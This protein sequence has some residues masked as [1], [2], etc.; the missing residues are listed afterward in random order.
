MKK[1]FLALAAL[2]AMTAVSCVKDEST[3][4]HITDVKGVVINEVYTFSD[5]SEADDLD[6]IELYNTTNEDID[7]TDVLMWEG[8]G[9]EEAWAFPKGTVIKAK[10]YYVV[11]CDK[12]GLL[13]DPVKYPAWGL[14]KG[15]D[16]FVVLANSDLKVIDEVKLPSLNENESYGRVTDGSADWQIFQQGTKGVKN[17][18][19]ARGVFVN[20]SGL[21]INE[22]YTDNSDIFSAS[23]WDPTVDFIEF[24][25]STDAEFDMSGFKVY[26]DK[27]E[28]ETSYTF[29]AGTVVPAKGFLTFD[30]YKENTAGPAFG[31]GAGGDWVFLY[32]A[33]GEKIDE[34][35]IP[36]I[37]KESGNRDKG[38]TY[39][40][41]PDGSTTLVWFT[42]ASKNASNNNSPVLEG[43][44]T[45]GPEQ[46]S[47]GAAKVVLNELCGNKAYDGQKFIELY[48][49]GNA[50]ADMAGWTIRKYASD[51]TDVEG[52]YNNCW[53]A[54]EGIKIA[55][56]GYLVLTADQTDPT[57]GFNAG[58]SAKKGVKFELVD[59]QGNVVD[60]FVRGEDADP[61]ME[62]GLD[63]NKEASFSRVPNGTGAWAYADPTPGAANGEATGEIE[64]HDPSTAVIPSQPSQPEEPAKEAKVVLNELCGNKA[65]DGQ[66]FIELYNAGNA[67]ADMAGWTIRKYASDATD[68]EGKYN[69]CWVATDG[70][71]IAAGAYL[72]LT[73]DQTDPTIGFNA[74]LSAKKGVK[75]E[76][77][78]PQ[79]NVVDK[80]VRGEDAD[81][82]MEEGL[83]ENK[84]ASFSRVP[85][86]TGAW[87]YADPTPGAANGEAT[88]EIEGYNK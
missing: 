76:L 1:I 19:P 85:N 62:E 9:S 58:L 66:K 40:R 52:K 35:E 68:V 81:P 75:F 88:G 70:I 53:V 42:V 80:F 36:S 63:E 24:Y 5:Q 26:D 21:Y 50:D 39:G 48:N 57:L 74:G 64:G 56:G 82:F 30:V 41:K 65:Y 45:P 4:F 22:V 84:E 34:I 11:D 43:S 29:P 27:H 51:A 16:E 44:E 59:P 46:P 72:V 60:K 38:Y 79:G 49:T 2:V 10:G 18:G 87:A 71:K 17:E 69:N 23:G 3:Y 20:T 31:L 33:A 28:E 61:F 14:S 47:T 7:L 8:G 12:Y 83:D 55:A 77:V 67:D 73:A 15:P 6:W 37:T 78:D 13:N 32:D 54:T 25:N 86:G